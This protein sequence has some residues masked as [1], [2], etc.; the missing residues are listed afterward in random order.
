MAKQTSVAPDTGDETLEKALRQFEDAFMAT[1][2]ER[3]RG[4]QCRD[5][6]DGFQ[7]TADEIEALRKRKQPIVTA[8]R[9]K[10]KVDSLIG[11][12]K[13]QRTDPKAYPRTPKHEKDADGATDAIR[14]V[15]DINDFQQ[16]RSDV[17]ENMIV[18]GAAAA[19]VGI[20]QS[21]D[22]TEIT[23]SWVPWDRYYRDPH[24]RKR[25]FSDATFMGEV[26]WMDEDEAEARYQGKGEVIANAY[27]TGVAVSETYDDRPKVIWSD[28][29]RRRVRVMK[30][31][32]KDPKK[33]WMTAI[34]CKGGFLWGPKVSPYKDEKGRPENDMVPVSAF[35]TRENERYGAVYNWLTVQDEVNKRRSKAL[36]RLSVHQVIADEGAVEDVGQAR[37]ELAKPDGYVEVRRDAKFD[38]IDGMAQMQGEMA[39]LQEAKGEIDVVGANPVLQGEGGSQ[40]GRSQEIQT[41]NA[42]A[43]YAVIFDALRNWSWRVYKAVWCR[44]RQY[45]TGPMWVRVT[46]DENNL[47]FVGLNQPVTVMSEIQRLQSEG[48]PIPPEL[49][50]M[51]QNDPEA[52]IR[53]ENPVGDLDVDIIV[54][55]GP[56][57]ITI[58]GEQFEQLVEL[59][60]SDPASIPTEMVIEASN[61]RNKDRILEHLKTKGIPP[62]VQQ[63]MQQMEQALQEAQGKL[64][65]AEQKSSSEK[66]EAQNILER[67]KSEIATAKADLDKQQAQM[68]SQ[69]AQWELAQIQRLLPQQNLPPQ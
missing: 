60:K 22:E 18:E 24:S 43:E 13:R 37:A 5:Y 41:Q 17:A 68:Q 54:E 1:L 16:V 14:F 32:W 6:Y 3:A 29:S 8:N 12:E 38:V 63:Q 20:R 35:V 51:A 44:V 19:C 69:H 2:N 50:M 49:M 25:D 26:I 34:L 15:C 67:V 10:P 4:E 7:W 48:Q 9:I 66:Q 40:S 30:H 53:T 61:L 57:T 23:I 59:K 52:V 39:L 62:Q 42:L 33:G 31:R 11:F 47:R 36:H 21:G 28:I 45:W 64:Q 27:E 65:E 56:D 55:D 58:Q 46:D